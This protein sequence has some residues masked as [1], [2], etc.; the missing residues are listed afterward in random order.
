[1]IPD[2]LWMISEEPELPPSSGTL[3]AHPGGPSTLST[4]LSALRT[5]EGPAPAPCWAQNVLTMDASP[6]A[7]EALPDPLDQSPFEEHLPCAPA[8]RIHGLRRTW[9]PLRVHVLQLLSQ[10]LSGAD[11]AGGAT[12]AASAPPLP[13]HAA[14]QEAVD[15]MAAL[16]ASVGAEATTYE[17]AEGIEEVPEDWT[18]ILAVGRLTVALLAAPPDG[19]A[20]AVLL[21]ATK[22]V[23][24]TTLAQCAAPLASLRAVEGYPPSVLSTLAHLLHLTLPLLSVSA[25]CWATLLPGGK[26][27]KKG[28]GTVAAAA[29]ADGGA[30][31]AALP[32]ASAQ[33]ADARAAVRE[34]LGAIAEAVSTLQVSLSA[35]DRRPAAC[36]LLGSEPDEWVRC[37]GGAAG[38]RAKAEASTARQALLAALE[39]EGKARLAELATSAREVAGALKVAAKAL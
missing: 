32:S 11:G 17:A 37:V 3:R 9:L 31:D 15:Q 4:A 14:A 22:L 30:P 8:R 12:A 1:M 25:M 29:E 10:T 7:L 18:A 28:G 16:V 26:K 24:T 5:A 20:D 19:A 39:A 38:E 13:A 2:C 23:L 34:T 6:A 35:A 36:V 27:K 33:P 21:A